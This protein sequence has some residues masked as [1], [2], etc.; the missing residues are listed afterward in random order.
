MLRSTF[1]PQ[2]WGRSLHTSR[3]A[4]ADAKE[5]SSKATDS[6]KQVAS[7]ASNTAS[8]AAATAQEYAGKALEQSQKLAKAIGDTSGK[9]LQNAGPRVNG[10]VDRVVG[11]QKPIVYW[12]KVSGEVAKQ[13]NSYDFPEWWTD[14]S[15]F[16]RENE[17]SFGTAV[18]RDV[19]GF[20]EAS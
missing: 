10:I 2:R 7:R 9:L 12:G 6:A 18:S 4:R 20:E 1:R 14:E 3:L 17:P 19:R 11:L 13:G 5:A 15:V 16:E 8:N